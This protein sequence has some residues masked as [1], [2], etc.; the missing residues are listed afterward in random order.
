[1]RYMSVPSAGS[2]TASVASGVVGCVV[3]VERGVEGEGWRGPSKEE[4]GRRCRERGGGRMVAWPQRGGGRSCSP[5]VCMSLYE[6]SAL[7]EL[8]AL[9]K[10]F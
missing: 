7:Y 2:T 8:Y 3:I 9:Y 4:E 1:M 5:C 6:L 10:L